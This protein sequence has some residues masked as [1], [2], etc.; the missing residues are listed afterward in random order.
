MFKK[1]WSELKPQLAKMF[2]MKWSVLK[3]QLAKML[4]K[5]W[6]ELK[7][8][9]EFIHS[10]RLWCV[11]IG[12]AVMSWKYWDGIK[13]DV[14]TTADADVT[15]AA[16]IVMA[17]A[18][19]WIFISADEKVRSYFEREG[20]PTLF[21]NADHLEKIDKRLIKKWLMKH[22]SLDKYNE[23]CALSLTWFLTFVAIALVG[24]TADTSNGWGVQSIPKTGLWIS[25][26]LCV[27]LHWY[28]HKIRKEGNAKWFSLSDNF[29][30]INDL[31][32]FKSGYIMCKSPAPL[33][34]WGDQDRYVIKTSMVNSSRMPGKGSLDRASV[35]WRL[36]LLSE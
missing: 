25:G 17:I 33:T 5:K 23:A 21:A 24:P 1:K 28:R 30:I 7:T 11:N 14:Q 8:Q 4:K 26:V 12:A 6:S 9:L 10:P 2:K 35:K 19:V 36:L 18:S 29:P 31:P 27:F 13:K 15:I 22:Y 16:L 32:G 3:P 20:V 34:Q